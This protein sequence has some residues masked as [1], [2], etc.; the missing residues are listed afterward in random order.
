MA[1]STAL[2]YALPEIDKRIDALVALREKRGVDPCTP[3]GE[4]VMLFQLLI[5]HGSDI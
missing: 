3:R 5:E 1:E 2:H 4:G